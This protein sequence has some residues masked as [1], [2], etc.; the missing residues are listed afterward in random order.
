MTL[1]KEDGT[2]E[3]VAVYREYKVLQNIEDAEEM[4]K[5]AGVIQN[6]KKWQKKS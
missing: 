6:L 4:I 2:R 1:S 3:T 5:D